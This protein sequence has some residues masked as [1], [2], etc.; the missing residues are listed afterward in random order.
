MKKSMAIILSLVLVACLS[1]SAL[2]ESTANRY[3]P[4][5]VK[6]GD[7]VLAAGSSGGPQNLLAGAW[8]EL[9][10]QLMP[11][12]TVNVETGGAFSNYQLVSTGETDIG[13]SVT[14]T[15]YEGWNGIENFKDL[16]AMQGVRSLGLSYPMYFTVFATESSGIKTV[17]DIAGKRY[18][19]AYVGQTAHVMGG[20]ML[21]VHGLSFDDCKI[22]PQ[23]ISE[24]TNMMKDRQVDVASWN[25]SL[26]Q[27]QLKD[28]SS[29]QKLVMVEWGEGKVDELAAKY[30]Q[31]STGYIPNG[32]YDFQ[33]E[34]YYTLAIVAD[35]LINK[36]LSDDLVYNMCKAYYD[37]L[38]Y[39]ATVCPANTFVTAENTLEYLKVP[40]HKGAAEYFEDIGLTVPEHLKPID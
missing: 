6:R 5:Q 11:E 38:E 19:P 8:A 18:T 16:G 24:C 35:I 31:Y 25:L 3:D 32:S 10:M 14:S 36:D 22:F 1:A 37:N 27:S 12:I 17:Y 40:L 13:F 7:Y 39:L 21:E 34:D 20:L 28:L 29:T 23:S 4:A 26:P 30:P 15:S 9:M 2:A 33:T